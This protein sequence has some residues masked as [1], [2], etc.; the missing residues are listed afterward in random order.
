MSQLKAFNQVV[1]SA[2]WAERFKTEKAAIDNIK[3]IAKEMG[4]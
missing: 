2:Y 1:N 3:H 4:L